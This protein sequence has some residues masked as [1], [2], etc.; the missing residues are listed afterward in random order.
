LKGCIGHFVKDR[1]FELARKIETDGRKGS[2]GDAGES[3]LALEGEVTAL[4]ANLQSI[5]KELSN[6]TS[7]C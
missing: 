3:L 2:L 4:S 5:V 1:P 7:N 6:E